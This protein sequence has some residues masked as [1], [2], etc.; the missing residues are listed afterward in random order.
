MP[1]CRT[2][3]WY[4]KA[5]QTKIKRKSYYEHIH[6]ASTWDG[7]VIDISNIRDPERGIA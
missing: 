5:G 3:P 1:S 7:L 6:M 2:N 4:K